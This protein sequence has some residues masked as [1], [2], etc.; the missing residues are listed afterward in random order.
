MKTIFLIAFF[1]STQSFAM[2]LQQA[3]QVIATVTQKE[4]KTKKD[5]EDLKEAISV[6]A[7]SFAQHN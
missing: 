6:V 3:K 4:N 7:G 1:I 2:N 5:I